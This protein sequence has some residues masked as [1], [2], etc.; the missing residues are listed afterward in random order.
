MLGIGVTVSLTPGLGAHRPRNLD[1]TLESRIKK[2]FTGTGYM[3]Q[4]LFID[5][6]RELDERV[7]GRGIALIMDNAPGHN[8][9]EEMGLRNITCIRLPPNTTSP[10]TDLK[11]AYPDRAASI[12]KQTDYG[13]L[14]YLESCVSRGPTCTFTNTITSVAIDHR[15]SRFFKPNWKSS[16]IPWDD[17]ASSELDSSDDITTQ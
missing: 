3:A 14:T 8:E 17:A 2:D 12:D 10:E 7:S 4:D 6:L 16:I 5:W 9:M 13:I 1:K 15:F 11:V